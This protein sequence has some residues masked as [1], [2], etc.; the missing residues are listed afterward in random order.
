MR[1]LRQVRRR[2]KRR[3]AV[4]PP[5]WHEALDHLRSRLAEVEL[6]L[7]QAEQLLLEQAAEVTDIGPPDAAIA[8][9]NM[10]TL[11]LAAVMTSEEMQNLLALTFAGTAG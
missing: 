8:R 5:P 2:L 11:G 4:A 3:N 9:D 7:E 10:R 6:A 1:P